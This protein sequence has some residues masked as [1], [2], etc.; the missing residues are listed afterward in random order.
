MRVILCTV[1][2]DKATEL[3]GLLVEQ[4][5]VACVNIVPAVTSVYRWEGQIETDTESLLIMKT[6]ATRVAAAT[7]AI[8][9]AHPYRVPEVIALPFSENEGNGE[10]LN[11]V[12][13][14][15]R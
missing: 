15:T 13:E 14:M 2:P 9:A 8:K 7:A 11:W 3:A 12:A 6:V 10:Y 4:R 1:P 5:L